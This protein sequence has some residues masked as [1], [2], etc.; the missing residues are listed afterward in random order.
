MLCQVAIGVENLTMAVPRTLSLAIVGGIMVSIL[1]C[2]K[3]GLDVPLMHQSWQ[4]AAVLQLNNR[5]QLPAV[6]AQIP[7]RVVFCQHSSRLGC[8]AHP[9]SCQPCL[10]H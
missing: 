2:H 6:L 1:V 10:K 9:D 8:A 3:G 4:L 7:R 5:S